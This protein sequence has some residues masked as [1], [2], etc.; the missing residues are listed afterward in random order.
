MIDLHVTNRDGSQTTLSAEEGVNL[1]EALR[2]AGI[3]GIDAICGGV[4][5][6]A[7]C[8]V[9]LTPDWFEKL[10]L[11]DENE[12]ELLA[13]SEHRAPTSRLSC[14]IPLTAELNG[15]TLTIAEED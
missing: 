14:Q 9:H 13:D 12:E 1:M 6:C 4:C 11:T 10:P 15:L 7:T 5:S 2:E 8:H 3:D